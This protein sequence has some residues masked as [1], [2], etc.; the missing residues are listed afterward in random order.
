MW[1]RL[2]ELNGKPRLV[3]VDL[4]E[5]VCGD[6]DAISILSF[7]SNTTLEVKESLEDFAQIL[8]ALGKT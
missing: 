4:V 6:D 5:D 3:N 1:L 8:G 2:T 7:V